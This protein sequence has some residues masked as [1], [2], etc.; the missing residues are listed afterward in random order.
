MKIWY[1]KIANPRLWLQTSRASTVGLG[2]DP[3]LGDHADAMDIDDDPVVTAIKRR[4]RTRAAPKAAECEEIK[5]DDTQE[6]LVV[7]L[8]EMVRDVSEERL[9]LNQEQITSALFRLKELQD[10]QPPKVS[11][12]PTIA[13]GRRERLEGTLVFLT[14]ELSVIPAENW[15]TYKKKLLQFCESEASFHMAFSQRLYKVMGI[16]YLPEELE[17]VPKEDFGRMHSV[18]RICATAAQAMGPEEESTDDLAEKWISAKKRDLDFLQKMCRSMR[19][20]YKA[21]APD[22]TEMPWEKTA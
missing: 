3:S 19:R 12:S 16:V 1:A 9:A 11:F 8:L 10:Q 17:A 2:Q 5:E 22:Q 14:S 15:V 4:P 6:Q 21:S 13:N 7:K 20:V 18:A